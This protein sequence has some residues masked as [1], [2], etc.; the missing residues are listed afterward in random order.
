MWC[1]YIRFQIPTPIE[2]RLEFKY[3]YILKSQHLRDVLCQMNIVVILLFLSDYPLPDEVL[4]AYFCDD[5][6]F[7]DG[8]DMDLLNA[9]ADIE[10][11]VAINSSSRIEL[12]SEQNE[13]MDDNNEE[14]LLAME[15]FEKGVSKS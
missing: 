14:L 4:P 10:E 12:H 9:S 2:V 8:D 5:D 15:N 1:I 7:F 11:M 3:M 6:E 13:D